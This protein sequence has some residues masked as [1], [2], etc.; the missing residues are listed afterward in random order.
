MKAALHFRTL[1]PRCSAPESLQSNEMEF[2]LNYTDIY[3]S[4][5]FSHLRSQRVVRMNVPGEGK[6]GK[7]G[8]KE[9]FIS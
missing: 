5:E 2:F 1:N 3:L 4:G 6:V 9:D 8:R 7:E